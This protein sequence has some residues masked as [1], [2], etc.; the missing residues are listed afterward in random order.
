MLLASLGYASLGL[1]GAL[2]VGAV[3]AVFVVRSGTILGPGTG[4]GTGPPLQPAID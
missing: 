4:P 3:A 2:L 1:L